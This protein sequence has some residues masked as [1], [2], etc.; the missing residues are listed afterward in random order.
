MNREEGKG[1]FSNRRVYPFATLYF[2]KCSPTV[3]PNDLLRS[4]I[5]QATEDLLMKK[6]YLTQAT[7]SSFHSLIKASHYIIFFELCFDNYY[8]F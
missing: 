6:K 4:S 7:F 2:F 8:V 3:P 1:A 5:N